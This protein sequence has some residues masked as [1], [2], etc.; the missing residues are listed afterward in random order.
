MVELMVALGVLGVVMIILGGSLATSLRPLL[1]GKQRAV[2]TN[3]AQQ[4]LERARALSFADVGLVKSTD[5]TLP[6]NGG[7]DSNIVYSGGGVWQYGGEPLAYASNTASHPF[8]PHYVPS[9]L[10]GSTTLTRWIW[11]TTIGN[12]KRVTVRV[13]WASPAVTGA[14]PYVRASTLISSAAFTAAGTPL[15]TTT[16]AGGE[17]H[18]A[19]II[20]GPGGT[21]DRIVVSSGN[22]C[23]IDCGVT[24]TAAA[25]RNQ[26][27]C[28]G[29]TFV[30]DHSQVSGGSEPFGGAT[31]N[32]L[33]DDDPATPT[34]TTD[35]QTVNAPGGA[36]PS[37]I[38]PNWIAQS[39]VPGSA[40][41]LST[42]LGPNGVSGGDDD[43]GY[44]HG[45]VTGPAALTLSKVVSSAAPSIP[46]AITVLDRIDSNT[47][48]ADA[49][50]FSD[51]GPVGT[52]VA[53][54]V[55]RVADLRALVMAA[56]TYSPA[57]AAT[58]GLL[59]IEPVT[60]TVTATAVSSGSA[61]APSVTSA[62]LRIWVYD[63]QNQLTVG[64]TCTRRSEPF[65]GE[66]AG[67][68]IVDHD[69][70]SASGLPPLTL[71]ESVSVPAVGPTM[72]WQV[73]VTEPA[74]TT[75]TQTGA[76]GTVWSAESTPLVASVHMCVTAAGASTCNPDGLPTPDKALDIGVGIDLG[77][78]KAQAVYGFP[79]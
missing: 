1:L 54:S 31:V 20:L 9:F 46:T 24:T 15:T 44:E 38:Y 79:V 41:C 45:S 16:S 66:P 71:D 59:R 49:E 74:A 52:L 63:P 47:S 17:K 37:D 50:T 61:P 26:V 28:S 22:S 23:Q 58:Y 42:V 33:A 7:A 11:V 76:R 53:T 40:S 65:V 62:M 43:L 72:R 57:I 70:A 69:I 75:S 48:T 8:N 18:S 21:P 4:L 73:S 78:V 27:A 64:T 25:I 77:S 30:A 10:A 2:A 39:S 35:S 55:K 12:L 3:V 5:A 34:N 56:P 19:S 29:S 36:P 60:A 68:C 13:Q 67:Y 14:A 32:T 51:M 6:E